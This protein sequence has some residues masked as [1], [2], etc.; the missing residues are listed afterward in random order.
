MN[1]FGF[2]DEKVSI[3]CDDCKKVYKFSRKHFSY[4]SDEYC[5]T[6]APIQCPNCK[7]L[8]AQ[9]TLIRAK[10]N[11][12]T[13]SIDAVLNRLKTPIAETPFQGDT[14]TNPTNYTRER[15]QGFIHDKLNSLCLEIERNKK[16]DETI[17]NIS[18]STISVGSV[19][20]S[21]NILGI[22]VTKE[23]Y[24]FSAIVVYKTTK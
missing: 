1:L 10:N 23:S 18:Y 8:V 24:V 14:S 12:A 19:S 17:S 7:K 5:K 6:N 11:A 22:P 16:S 2:D 15:V 9:N 13:A 3:E 20:N 21:F 4:V